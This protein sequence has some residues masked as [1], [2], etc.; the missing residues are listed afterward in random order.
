MLNRFPITTFK[1]YLLVLA[2]MIVEIRPH[3][4]K[5]LNFHNFLN[6][7]RFFQGLLLAVLKMLSI[8]SVVIH[9]VFIL[10]RVDL[11][12]IF[13]ISKPFIIS[14]N[15]ARY[16]SGCFYCCQSFFDRFKTIMSN[17]QSYFRFRYYMYT[18]RI[19][20]ISG[21]HRKGLGLFGI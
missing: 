9:T 13:S 6:T 4:L 8:E 16:N 14:A 3:K 17:F 2:D 1:N 12:K 19:L 18:L 15:I 21:T 5:L 20:Y 10:L 7:S 11:A